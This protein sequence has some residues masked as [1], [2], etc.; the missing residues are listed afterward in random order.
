MTK[1]LTASSMT[2]NNHTGAEKFYHPTPNPTSN[3]VQSPPKLEPLTRTNR[4]SIKIPLQHFHDM[5]SSTSRVNGT[6]SQ[7]MPAVLR[8]LELLDVERKNMMDENDTKAPSLIWDESSL[9]SRSATETDDVLENTELSSETA[10]MLAFALDKVEK[11]TSSTSLANDYSKHY[12]QSGE[13]HTALPGKSSVTFNRSV[14]S[15]PSARTPEQRRAMVK[16]TTSLPGRTPTEAE[17]WDSSRVRTASD[18]NKLSTATSASPILGRTLS[19]QGSMKVRSCES[20]RMSPVT[21]SPLTC[22]FARR[23]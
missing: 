20:Q 13:E 9:I 12:H 15:N 10:K 2:N 7:E 8:D 22:R 18:L 5:Y 19:R 11:Y 16:L 23:L 6:V 14:N 3:F 21:L 1:P 17:R 4:G